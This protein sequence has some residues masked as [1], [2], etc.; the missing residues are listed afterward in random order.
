MPIHQPVVILLYCLGEAFGKAVFRHLD[1]L[2]ADGGRST[3]SSS[4]AGGW[5]RFSAVRIHELW[6]PRRTNVGV[7]L[8]APWAVT[9]SID[10]ADSAFSSL[11]AGE[12]V[13]FWHPP[14]FVL[15][16]PSW[17]WSMRTK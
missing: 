12:P 8:L 16:S 5:N 7:A 14:L 9:R 2:R 15:A 1:A 17:R 10:F 13:R 11:G 6:K 3:E 4:L